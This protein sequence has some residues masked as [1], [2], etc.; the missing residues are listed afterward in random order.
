MNISCDFAIHHDQCTR[1][2]LYM[3][4][5]DVLQMCDDA[6]NKNGDF[7]EDTFDVDMNKENM[8]MVVVSALFQHDS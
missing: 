3:F 7:E 4:R 1:Q 2:F 6:M 5:H 8:N